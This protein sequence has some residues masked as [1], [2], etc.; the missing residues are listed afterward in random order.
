M[1]TAMCKYDKKQQKYPAFIDFLFICMLNAFNF[2]KSEE[3]FGGK[4]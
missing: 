3:T 2:R 4:K 1:A